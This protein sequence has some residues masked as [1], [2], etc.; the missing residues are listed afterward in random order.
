MASSPQVSPARQLP[1]PAAVVPVESGPPAPLTSADEPAPPPPNNLRKI[2]VLLITLGEEASGQIV[3]Q[4]S[5]EE[6]KKVGKAIGTTAAITS[7]E[8]VA[9]LREYQ[10]LLMA[11]RCVVKG[12][13]DYASRMLQS[14]FGV[15]NSRRLLDQVSEAIGSE[16][17]SFDSLQK[18]EPHQLA[19]VLFREHSQ[20]IALILSHLNPWQAAS[21]MSALPANRRAELAMRMATLEEISPDVIGKIAQVIGEKLEGLGDLSRQSYG[22]LRVVAEMLNRL[23]A[24]IRHEMLTEIGQTDGS[25]LNNIR[26]LMFVFEDLLSIDRN[27][28]K[29]ITAGVDTRVL[30]VALKGSSEKLRN[31]FAQSM[32][33]NGA[34][35]LM[36]DIDA[37]GPV[38]LKEVERAQQEILA[39]ARSLEAKGTISLNGSGDE[40]V[41]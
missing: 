15:E 10:Q 36:E 27:G 40:Y 35:I 19:N 5:P 41:M 4:L 33:K 18:A 8:A 38:R 20:T 21:L 34:Q 11:R 22:G 7:E 9:T 1:A 14:A 25:M 30:A 3:R 2:A 37:T 12:G 23:D 24:K 32:S 26:E 39:F 17:A 6:I 13:M 28:M 31:H 16:M 29:L